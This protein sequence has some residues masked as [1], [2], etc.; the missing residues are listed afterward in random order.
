MT[1][2]PKSGSQ[3]A[4]E[5]GIHPSTLM[6]HLRALGVP[7]KGRGRGGAYR[8]T[9][10]IEQEVREFLRQKSAGKL[11]EKCGGCYYQDDLKNEC[12]VSTDPEYQWAQGKCWIREL[13]EKKEA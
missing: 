6:Y 3:F 1:M 4:K 9:P 12:T 5:L 13:L 11:V 2:K 10:E 7:R 8:I